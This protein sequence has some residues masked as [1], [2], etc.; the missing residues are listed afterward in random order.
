MKVD[1]KRL[2]E[3]IEE[4][5]DTHSDAMRAT[6]GAVAEMVELRHEAPV[7][8]LPRR[9]FIN[10]SLFAAGA[11][12]LGAGALYLS[13]ATITV[14]AADEDVAY[15]Q[16]AAAIENL[17]ISVYTQA[18]SLPPALSGAANPVIAAFVTNTIKQHKEHAATFNG[19]LT[20]LS[21]KIQSGIDQ[22]VQDTVVKPA[23][24]A[25]AGPADVV[26]LA[27]TLEDAAAASYVKWAGDADPKGKAFAPLVAIAPVEAQHVAVL[28][29]VQGLLAASR[30]DLIAL[31]APVAQLPAAAGDIAFP[32][33]R[34]QTK[35][36]RPEDEGKVS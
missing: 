23:L 1:D 8:E 32:N 27:L 26:K 19:A 24:S 6:H 34:Y 15:L 25:I 13:R 36:A 22:P 5:N 33:A 18:A 16:T 20:A 28:L 7:S 10:R 14:N 21:A 35:N 11:L 17:A 29:A 12:G 4:S 31:P 30:P 2:S 3:L 9:R